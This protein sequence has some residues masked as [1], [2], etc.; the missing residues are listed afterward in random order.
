MTFPE[1]ASG[2]RIVSMVEWRNMMIVATETNLFAILTDGSIEEMK[3][4]REAR[5]SRGSAYGSPLSAND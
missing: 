2:Q 1:I 3:F 5:P 4:E